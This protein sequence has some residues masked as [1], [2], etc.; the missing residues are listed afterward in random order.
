MKDS[1][2]AM[3]R[4]LCSGWVDDTEDFERGLCTP[5]RLSTDTKNT[6]EIRTRIFGQALMRHPGH[7]FT[8][9]LRP[10]SGPGFLVQFMC[11]NAEWEETL[12]DS[13]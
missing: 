1:S 8:S 9:A 10:S 7:K 4:V 11:V 13:I 2:H 6:S 12:A 3:L 5:Y